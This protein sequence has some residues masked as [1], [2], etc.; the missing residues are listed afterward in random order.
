M[1]KKRLYKNIAFLST[2][3]VVAGLFGTSVSAQDIKSQVGKNQGVKVERTQNQKRN[4]MYYGDWSI[5]GGEGNYYP[6]DIP[7]DQLTHLNYAFM[8]FDANGELVFTDKDAACDAPVGMEGVTWGD[9]N[10]GLINAFQELKAKNPNLKIGISLGGWSKSGDFSEV[11]ASK[12]KRANLIKNTLSFIRYTNMD[13]VDLDW[14]YPASVREPDKV[15][16]QNDEGTPNSKP[17]DKQNYITLLKEFREALTKQGE[18]IGKY[19]ELSVALPAPKAKLDEGIDIK[20]LFDVVDFANIMTYDMR[21]AW[22]TASGHQTPLYTNPNDPNKGKGLSVDESV[23]YLMSQGAS[24]EKIVVGAAYYTRGWEKVSDDGIDKNNPGLF[25]AAEV[26][27]KDADQRLTPG[28]DNEAPVKAGDGGRRGG[29]WSYRSHDKLK[30]KY[31]GLKEYWDDTAK[32]PYLYNKDTGAFFTYDNVKSIEEK[33][34]Y[35]HQNN[36]GGMIGWMA[37][38]DKQTSSS[39]RDE[40]TKATKQALYGDAELQKHTLVYDNLDIEVEIVPFKES[41]SENGGFDITIKNKEKLEEKGTV[42]KS[43]ELGA[44]TVKNAKIYIK[45]NGNK[46]TGGDYT[47]G[48]IGQEGDYSVI[49]LGSIYSGKILKPGTDYKMRLTT[50]KAPENADS[51]DSIYLTQRISQQGPEIAPQLL[52]GE[53][54]NK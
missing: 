10:A 11:A 12:E 38:Q 22:D 29:V 42:L 35:V 7:A 54:K 23:Q 45:T 32:A 14:E 39:S 15:D 24:P 5:W 8:D 34:N 19:Y 47:V 50:E 20:N 43:V 27:A 37:S 17:E 31:T 49:D 13:F 4:V 53:V 21:G 25:G 52:H 3:L 51:I 1:V 30:S 26:I 44:E 28:A 6:K 33:V 41:W 36:L 9:P 2:C 40:L 46:I 16:N 18:E 48:N